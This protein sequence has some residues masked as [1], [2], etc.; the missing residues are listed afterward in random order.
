MMQAEACGRRAEK[1]EG[2]VEGHGAEL[3]KGAGHA[4]HTQEGH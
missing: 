2:G 1:E 3:Q 4:G